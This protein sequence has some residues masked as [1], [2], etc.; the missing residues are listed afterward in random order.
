MVDGL[1]RE[2]FEAWLREKQ[3]RELVGYPRTGCDCPLA[4]F[5]RERGLPGAQVLLA[6]YR[7]TGILAEDRPLPNWALQFR[8]Q[9]DRS[10]AYGVTARHAL[11]ALQET[12]ADA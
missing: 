8:G 9:V 2:D 11:R 12:R 3:P 7:P 6:S 5:L 10:R 4:R 1:R